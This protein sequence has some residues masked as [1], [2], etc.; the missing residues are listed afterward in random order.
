MGSN[1]SG[2]ANCVPVLA[3]K[4]KLPSHHVTCFSCD[5]YL[6]ILILLADQA[7]LLSYLSAHGGM[8]ALSFLFSCLFFTFSLDGDISMRIS[9]GVETAGHVL[10]TR[11]A[12]PCGHDRKCG[13]LP[14]NSILP[15]L[16]AKT[17]KRW[18]RPVKRRQRIPNPAE[19]R[20]WTINLNSFQNGA[21]AAAALRLV[22]VAVAVTPSTPAPKPRPAVSFKSQP[23]PFIV[24][25][26]KS[27]TSVWLS[28]REPAVLKSTLRCNGSLRDQNRAVGPADAKSLHLSTRNIDV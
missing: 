17:G 24:N 23:L 10:P 21:T 19:A 27:R 13:N 15:A 22:F 9:V 4:E 8:P 26:A 25:Q 16:L 12:P 7:C 1:F 14:R 6:I 5:R 18:K 3:T 20:A 2:V 11:Q 28:E